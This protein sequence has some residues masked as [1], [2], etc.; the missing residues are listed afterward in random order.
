MVSYLN[1][2]E[3]ADVAFLIDRILMMLGSK[4]ISASGSRWSVGGS[5]SLA[6]L[7]RRSAQDIPHPTQPGRSLWDARGDVGPYEGPVDP[8]FAA[9]YEASDPLRSLTPE[10]ILTPL[11]SGSDYTPFLQHLGVASMDGG[12]GNTPGD[13]PYHY[14]SV[15]DSQMWQEKYGDPGFARHIAVARHLGLTALR[16]ADAIILPLNTTQYALELE[17]Y[18]ER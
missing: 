5:P 15:Y 9:M 8:D 3:P 11:G 6:H 2:G 12:F 13:A 16:I 14:H 18:L 4:D 17:F 7:I 10:M 1:V